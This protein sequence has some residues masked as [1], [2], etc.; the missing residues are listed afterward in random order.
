MPRR[1]RIRIGALE[2]LATQLRFAPRGA[3][4]RQIER[5][6]RL[7][8]EIDPAGA[9]AE[10][11][12]AWRITG[13]RRTIEEPALLVGEA[14]LGDLSAFLERLSEESRL[15]RSEV[16]ADAL[17]ID[18]LCAR[19]RV[20][21][22]S[23]ERYRR[24]GLLG[25]RVRD[26]GGAIVLVFK[27]AIISAFEARHAERLRAAGEF[28]RMDEQ[29]RR[30]VERLG[31]RLARVPGVSASAAAGRIAPRVE[32]GR[33]TIRRALLSGSGS[34]GAV[35]AGVGALTARER[36][37]IWRAYRWGVPASDIAERFNR[38]RGAVHRIVNERRAE[39]LRRLDLSGPVAPHFL[40]AARADALL[41]DPIVAQG[42][43]AEGER[44]VA[45]FAEAWRDA[46]AMDARRERTLA[47]AYLL[48]R[49][50]GAGA[51]AGLPRA[52]PGSRALDEAETILRWASQVK[53]ELARGQAG[54]A[55]R[56]VEERIGPV[57]LAPSEAGPW[58]VA[59]MR[60]VC[61]A[62]D[63]FDPFRAGRLAASSSLAIARALAPA[64]PGRAQ[65]AR[66]ARRAA[67]LDEPLDDWTRAAA[68]WNAWLAPHPAL[69]RGAGALREPLEQ[70]VL[71]RFGLV[72]A[73]PMTMAEVTAR[74][75]VT[76]AQVV[77][78]TVE[79]TRAARR[80]GHA[81]A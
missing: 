5:A 73:R 66:Q 33:E 29:E 20:S 14:L 30:R 47:E 74:F 80:L 13:Y 77:R 38:S 6:E 9:Y 59:A 17:S 1:S 3:A 44:T 52:A 26:Q 10:D 34:G 63:Q 49:F 16:G 45:E 57:L 72:G 31:A 76:E 22:K 39:L 15:E 60:A 18:D 32:R 50:K 61:R 4:L 65:T 25:L 81:R 42:L 46:R 71:A 24:L 7:A 48:L 79:A 51:I 70:V 11:W 56:S 68:D 67:R 55:L 43:G 19:W 35:F 54:L 12:V 28:R 40:D 62:I 2:D 69:R 27:P 21:R 53:V 58:I 78:A 36:T 8:A 23:I 37:I 75:G 64:D 41:H